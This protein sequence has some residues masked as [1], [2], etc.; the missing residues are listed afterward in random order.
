MNF[1][2]GSGMSD[3]VYRVTFADPLTKKMVTI[4][5]R[6]ISDSGLGPFHV[7]LSGF[8]FKP[9]GRLIDPVEE[10]L[11]NRFQDTRALHVSRMSLGLIEEVGDSQEVKLTEFPNVVPFTPEYSNE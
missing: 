10:T 4:Q 1:R 11:R 5:V 3:H 7:R 9:K 6:E 2:V 8:V